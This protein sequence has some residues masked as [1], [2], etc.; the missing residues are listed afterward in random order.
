MSDVLAAP[1]LAPRRKPLA[2]TQDSAFS[3]RALI[4]VTISFLAIFLFAPLV[5][6]FSEALSKGSGA[7][8]KAFDDADALAAIRLTLALHDQPTHLCL[9]AR[10]ARVAF[11]G[12]ALTD[13][14]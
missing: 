9:L 6:V 13:L 12:F 2:V 14:P 10:G 5:V 8:L 3:R 7:F 1:S 4:A 11:I